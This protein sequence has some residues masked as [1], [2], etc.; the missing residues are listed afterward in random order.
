M[1][2]QE[3]TTVIL[4][5][6]RRGKSIKYRIFEV[7]VGELSAFLPADDLKSTDNFYAT[8]TFVEGWFAREAQLKEPPKVRPAD[9]LG[10]A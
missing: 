4:V 5:P 1:T 9:L 10:N 7:N 3:P 6:T 2:T 8:Q